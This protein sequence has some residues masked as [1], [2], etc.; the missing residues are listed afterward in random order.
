L[1]LSRQQ[2]LSLA[3]LPTAVVI[4]MV[5][6]LQVMS[7]Q[8][9]VFT[10]LASSVFLVYLD[11][12][13]PTNRIRTFLLAQGIAALLGFCT[14]AL[15]GTGVLAAGAATILTIVALIALDAI[16]P[17]AMSTVLSFAFH[18]NSLKTLAIFGVAMGGIASLFVLQK[19]VF[20]EVQK[21][22]LRITDFCITD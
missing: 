18:A 8:C 6:G 7:E 1:G 22:S 14:V 4:L 19:V 12:E 5:G 10:S 21:R 13:H 11:Y 15:L 3:I 17:P 9:L 2:K 16:H 20:R